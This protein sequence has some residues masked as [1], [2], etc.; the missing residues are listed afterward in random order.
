MRD[1]ELLDTRRD[2][3]YIFYRLTEP[4]LINLLVDIGKLFGIPTE[5]IESL[6]NTNPLP[7]C[8]CPNCTGQRSPC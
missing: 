7:H 3:R 6:L 2:G 8:C 1:A 5:E 4:Q